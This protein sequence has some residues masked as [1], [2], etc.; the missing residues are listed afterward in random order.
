M[1]T[2]R[3][4]SLGIPTYI[5]TRERV[6][7]SS[8]RPCGAQYVPIRRV[9]SEESFPLSMSRRSMDIEVQSTIY[10]SASLTADARMQA[11]SR[12]G[13]ALSPSSSS[14]RF[15]RQQLHILPQYPPP[16]TTIAACLLL[17]LGTVKYR[18]NN[19]FDLLIALFL[20]LSN[21]WWG[22]FLQIRAYG[23]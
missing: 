12:D 8:S 11:S 10:T 7:S 5:K 20:V 23:Q 16:K 19:A 9:K 15:N 2:H 18:A 1:Y 17:I 13:S 22:N 6:V 21:I 4:R 14:I 3:V